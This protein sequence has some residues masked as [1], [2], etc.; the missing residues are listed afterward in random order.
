MGTLR[1]LGQQICEAVGKRQGQV[2][3]TE[4]T[5]WGF[6]GTMSSRLSDAPSGSVPPDEAWNGAFRVFVQKYQGI[7]SKAIREFL[8]GK[9]GRHFAD[10]V[11]DELPSDKPIDKFKIDRAVRRVLD[12]ARD[13]KW[14]AKDLASLAGVP[15]PEASHGSQAA[16]ASIVNGL[17]D[18]WKEVA[19]QEAKKNWKQHE[20]AMHA[21]EDKAQA[22]LDGVRAWFSNSGRVPTYPVKHSAGKTV[23]VTIPEAAAADP[24]RA[25]MEESREGA[26]FS[27]ALSELQRHWQEIQHLRAR[28]YGAGT[29]MDAKDKREREELNKQHDEEVDALEAMLK[30]AQKLFA[31]WKAG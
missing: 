8:D 16:L 19:L 13:G 4:N 7:P 5:S 1:Q 26:R 18:A 17:G 6:F 20:A 12:S 27:L 25:L 11:I 15:A 9:G 2:L 22:L 3:P 21:L 29:P 24:K 14:I 30:Q 28:I 10:A 23:R 31:S